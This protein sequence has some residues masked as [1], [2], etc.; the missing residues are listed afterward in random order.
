MSFFQ[1]FSKPVLL[2][3]S[4]LIST[5]VCAAPI[6]VVASF[7]ILGDWIT[8][9]GG[10]RVHVHTLIGPDQDAHAWQPSPGLAKQFAGARLVVVNGVGLDVAV[11]KLAVASGFR[12]QILVASTGVK[13]LALH[14]VEADHHQHEGEGFDPH[15]WQDIAAASVYVRNIASALSKLDPAGNAYYQSRAQAYI[16]QLQGLELWAQQ[17][18]ATL[19]PSQR[20]AIVSHD[21]FA[22]FA[23]R[24]D[25]TLI[26]VQGKSG[27]GQA[28]AQLVAGLIRQIKS[29]RLKAVFVENINNSRLTRQIAEET[30]VSLGAELYSDALSQAGGRAANYL[31]F[32][33]HNVNAFLVGMR[34]N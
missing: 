26:P 10:E 34:K 17:Q 18:F 30:G 25:L 32:Y 7:S 23:K 2:F 5:S 4:L 28:S 29:T 20:R 11:S 12:G 24:F 27:E 19:K 9:V 21:A 1:S 8:Q 31:D 14:E 22:Y 15:A 6:S 3:F 33:R 13:L 16:R